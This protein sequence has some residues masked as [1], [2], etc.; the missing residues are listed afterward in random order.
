[1]DVSI[2]GYVPCDAITVVLFCTKPIIMIC[3][4]NGKQKQHRIPAKRFNTSTEGVITFL[5]SFLVYPVI[6]CMKQILFMN[7]HDIMI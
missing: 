3:L 1:M 6:R 4:Y 5:T 7:V 2:S